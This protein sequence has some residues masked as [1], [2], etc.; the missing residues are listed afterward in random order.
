MYSTERSLLDRIVSYLVPTPRHFIAFGDAKLSARL[1]SGCS[2]DKLARHVRDKVPSQV[3]ADI[4]EHRSSMLCSTTR[5]CACLA[6]VPI[7]SCA[8]H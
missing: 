7:I 2:S 1:R 3:L 4:K 8:D 6:F 5:R